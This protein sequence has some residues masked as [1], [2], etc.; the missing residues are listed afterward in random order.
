MSQQYAPKTFLRQTSNR[1]LRECFAREGVL[2]DV[3]WNA[4]PEHRVEYVWDRWQHLPDVSRTA[5]ERLFE[6]A[7]QLA[8][9][10][11][12]QALIDECNFHQVDIAAEWER[13]GLSSFRDRA[14]WVALYHSRAFQVAG[15]INH[16]HTLPMR[17]WKKRGNMPQVQPNVAPEAIERFA[18]AISAYFRQTQG[19]GHRCTVDAYLRAHR[20]HYFFVYPDD[21][22]NTYLGHDDGGQFVRRPQRPAFEVVFL[23]DPD[24]GTLELFAHGNKGV[25]LSLQTIFCREMLGQ[26]LPPEVANS[27]PYE[28]NGLKSRGFGF[29]TDPNDGVE[30]VRIRKLRLSVLGGHKRRIWLEA[31]PDGG[32]DDIY[33][34]MDE[35]LNETNLPN[36]LVN[37]TVATIA[38]TISPLNSEK[39]GTVTFDVSYPDSSNLKSEKRERLRGIAEKHLK[40]WGI[41]RA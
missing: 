7:E 18:E 13:E 4:I 27:H 32:T 34:M 6:D 33:D 40:T 41:D 25:R 35:Y 29:P 5:I 39:G 22:A 24:D 11:G 2:A 16:A 19:R 9:E 1:L 8:S 37:V 14:M 36:S 15:I 3:D 17:Y 31:D 20:L 21:Y 12:I 23:F 38:M 10:Q 30:E 28:L 26:E